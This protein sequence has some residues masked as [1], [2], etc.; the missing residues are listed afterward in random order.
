MNKALNSGRLASIGSWSLRGLTPQIDRWQSFAPK[1]GS[2]GSFPN[3]FDSMLKL[4]TLIP[5][6][7]DDVKSTQISRISED[8]PSIE[9]F[10]LT[11]ILE[12]HSTLQ[13]GFK[14]PLTTL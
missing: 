2:L 1:L 6:P 14:A 8:A 9:A 12:Q 3:N 11:A 13:L 4:Y 5:K 10:C 7:F